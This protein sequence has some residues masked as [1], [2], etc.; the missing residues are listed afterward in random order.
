MQIIPRVIDLSHWDDVEDGFAGAVRAGIWGVINKASEG[1]GSRDM[2][3]EWRREPAKVAGLLYGAYH[4]IRP[5]N[6]QRQVEFFFGCIGDTAD[7]RLALDYEDAR[8]PESN[9]RQ[10]CS[11]VFNKTGRYPTLYGGAVIKAN[12][13]DFT[14]HAYFWKQIPLWLSHYSA[15]PSWPTNIWD[16]PWLWQYT[17]DGLGPTPHGVPGIIPTT[18]LDMDS[19]TGTRD[20][21]VRE[22]VSSASPAPAP[23]PPDPIGP[24]AHGRGSW[25]SQFHGIYH[26]VDDTDT[27]NSNALGVPDDCQGV[28]FYDHATLGKWFVVSAPNGHSSLEQQTEIGP[29]PWTGRKIDISAVCAERLGYSP[30]TFPT[31]GEFSWSRAQAPPQVAALSPR[32]QAVT[33]KKLRQANPGYKEIAGAAVA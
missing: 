2:S 4:F 25:Y 1:Y 26:W 7:L 24:I 15:H 28:S 29:A 3:F 23:P 9:A 13:A 6:V 18:K 8:V 27:P 31:N 5:G 17:G 19:Y 33:W 14:S 12:E 16:V 11:L 30:T 32:A 21:L 10:F 22:W 20:Q